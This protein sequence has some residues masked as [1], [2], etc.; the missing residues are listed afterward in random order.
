M[1]C[2][3]WEIA[4]LGLWDVDG[5]GDEDI[6]KE[7]WGVIDGKMEIVFRLDHVL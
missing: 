7:R 5:V 4:G 2:V 6:G 1:D 3:L